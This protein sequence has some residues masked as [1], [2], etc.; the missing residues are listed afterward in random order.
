MSQMINRFE[1]IHPVVFEIPDNLHKLK[2]KEKVGF[3]GGAA[4][5][6]LAESARRSGAVLG[7]LEKRDNGAPIPCNGIYW[8]IS[9]KSEAVGGVVSLTPVGIDVETIRPVTEALYGRVAE[10]TEWK[11]SSND[12]LDTFFRFWTAKEAVLKALGIGFAGMGKC[13]VVDIP[14]DDHLALVFEGHD[15]QVE[16]VRAN[17]CLISVTQSATPI[18]WHIETYPG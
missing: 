6:A 2:G 17:S 18:Q 5:E 13:R 8:S 9:H 16:H 15:W 7:E 10:E 4:R 11:L 3:L 14:D 1:K 12:R